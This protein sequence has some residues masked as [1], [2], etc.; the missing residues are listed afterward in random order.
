M[1]NIDTIYI[2]TRAQQ[3][4]IYFMRPPAPRYYVSGSSS[5]GRQKFR[6]IDKPLSAAPTA[7]YSEP[8]R[9]SNRASHD[10]QYTYILR[11]VH[12][13]HNIFIYEDVR[14][15]SWYMRV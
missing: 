13:I 10:H 5:L 1:Y 12:I 2:P 7:G 6:I 15:W 3:S 8:E 14:E 4:T 11:V 9:I